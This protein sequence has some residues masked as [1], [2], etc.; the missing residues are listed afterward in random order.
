MTCPAY[1]QSHTQSQVIVTVRF[2]AVN[3]NSNNSIAIHV[4][5]DQSVGYTGW[6]IYMIIISYLAFSIISSLLF[7]YIY[8]IYYP[9]KIIR[10]EKPQHMEEKDQ[11]NYLIYENSGLEARINYPPSWRLKPKTE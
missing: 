2:N 1:Y 8:R 10:K 7:L 3:V 9:F 6:Q 4:S 5:S 11:S